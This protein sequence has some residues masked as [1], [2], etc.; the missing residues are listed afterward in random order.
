VVFGDISDVLEDIVPWAR[1]GAALRPVEAAR[2][3][4]AIAS[5][6]ALAL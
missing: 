1:L 2:F 3:E 5:D 4:L 6:S